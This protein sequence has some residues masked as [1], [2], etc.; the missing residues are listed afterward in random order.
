M[1][2]SVWGKGLDLAEVLWTEVK[3]GDLFPPWFSAVICSASHS[4]RGSPNPPE[5][6]AGIGGCR[7]KEEKRPKRALFC[8]WNLEFNL[9]LF[10]TLFWICY[11][12]THIYLHIVQNKWNNDQFNQIH[13]FLEI[14]A[15]YLLCCGSVTTSFS[16]TRAPLWTWIAKFALAVGV[17]QPQDSPYA[18]IVRWYSPLSSTIGSPWRAF[19]LGLYSNHIGKAVPLARV[20]CLIIKKRCGHW[21]WNVV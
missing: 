5:Q 4:F 14:T 2:L 3:G 19:V 6:M 17:F 10:P 8:W 20:T 21:R 1:C 16:W 11:T 12:H 18:T 15:T 9:C 7:E 13:S